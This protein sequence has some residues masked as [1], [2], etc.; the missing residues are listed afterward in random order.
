MLSDW[1]LPFHPLKPK[2]PGS[3]ARVEIRPL[4]GYGRSYRRRMRTFLRA[5]E[6]SDAERQWPPLFPFSPRPTPSSS[7]PD[8]DEKGTLRD[9]LQDA[10]SFEDDVDRGALRVGELDQR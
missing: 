10:V 5:G 7:Q 8:G 4:L 3:K 6:S 1:D 9:R 2:I